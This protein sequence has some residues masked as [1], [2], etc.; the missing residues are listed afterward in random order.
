MSVTTTVEKIPRVPESKRQ[1]LEEMIGKCVANLQKDHREQ[2]S[3]LVLEFADIFAI[4]GELG[5]TSK[6]K[7]SIHTGDAQP[8]HQ[9]V[10]RHSVRDR[11]C[12]SCLQ[13][14]KRRM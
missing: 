13:R 2:L 1:L 14:C 4:D 10:Q 11:R 12:R 9:P 5:R 6:I 8:I 7:H 3:Q